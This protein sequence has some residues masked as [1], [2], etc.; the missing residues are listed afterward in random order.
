[1]ASVS[2]HHWYRSAHHWCLST[3]QWCRSAHHLCWSAHHWCRSARHRCRSARHWCWSAHHWCPSAHRWC[4]SAH[5]WCPSTHHCCWS[6]NL[7]FNTMHLSSFVVYGNYFCNISVEYFLSGVNTWIR[8]FCR[9]PSTEFH[10][11]TV[12]PLVSESYFRISACVYC[13]I[14]SLHFIG[15]FTFKS[16]MYC[17]CIIGWFVEFSFSIYECQS[18]MSWISLECSSG[19][20]YGQTQTGRSANVFLTFFD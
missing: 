17:H 2:A 12:W 15:Q 13:F 16:F 18:H 14:I 19:T 1:M 6:F 11:P 20:H 4:R 3:H 7:S 8:G 5:H 10:R 9:C